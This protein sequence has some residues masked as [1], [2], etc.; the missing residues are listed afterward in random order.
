M[1]KIKVLYVI[2]RIMVGGAEQVFIDILKLM[3]GK[4]EP[5]V[6]LISRSEPQQ[7]ERIQ[8]LAK[9]FELNR[10]SRFS[11]T[12]LIRTYRIIKSVDLLH[13]HLR[14]TLRYINLVRLYPSKKKTVIFHDHH[15]ISMISLFN[16][17]LMFKLV[18]LDYYLAV[19]EGVLSWAR[20]NWKFKS[21]GFLLNLPSIDENVLP[22]IN[23]FSK[24]WGRDGF[25]CV[26][27]IKKAKNQKFALQLAHSLNERIIFYGNNQDS[28]YFNNL[29]SSRG[30]I[31]EGDN[32]PCKHFD[33]FQFG[34]C[35]SI[36]ESGPLVILEYFVAGLPFLSYKTGGIADILHKYVPEYFLDSF[37]IS[38]WIERYNQL[39]QNYQ[40]IPKDLIKLVLER[41][42]NRDVY[43]NKLMEIYTKCL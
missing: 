13:V 34:L 8:G 15:H 43:A 37:E 28:E 2:D 26:G 41:E 38:D 40:R 7:L 9:V 12:S 31:V 6:L 3:Q 16:Q 21:S 22:L 27:N 4:V 5:F 29:I 30:M 20:D 10:N 14:P 19:N 35:T 42:F 11:V 39:S 18:P 32:K 36:S 25:I 33:N 1:S 17:L 23:N 24:Q